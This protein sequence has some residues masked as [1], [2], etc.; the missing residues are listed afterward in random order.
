DAVCK[1]SNDLFEIIGD[2][3]DEYR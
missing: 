2:C 3:G 1:K